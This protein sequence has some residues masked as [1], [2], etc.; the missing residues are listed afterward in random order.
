M[1]D[2]MTTLLTI[3]R[4][5]EKVNDSLNLLADELRRRGR[6]HDDSKLRAV[7]EFGAFVEINTG[8]RR[9]EFN[10]LEMNAILIRHGEAIELHKSRNSHH[11]E[12]HEDLTAMP[13]L[14]VIEMVI[15][16]QAAA[17]TYGKTPLADSKKIMLERYDFTEAQKWVIDE[18]VCILE[19]N[20]GTG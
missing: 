20:H 4:H 7:D 13:L 17:S 12:Y 19:A 11:P 15:D 10:S 9:Y 5:R 6:V 2:D 3:I 8:G 14:D 16:W 1:T 18:M